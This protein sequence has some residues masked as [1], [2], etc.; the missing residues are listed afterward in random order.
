MVYW[1]SDV[2]QV[3]S[4]SIV[5]VKNE[6]ES[7]SI[8][9]CDVTELKEQDLIRGT[10][11][12]K[13][14]ESWWISSIF[15]YCLIFMF[16]YRWLVCWM[17]SPARSLEEFNDVWVYLCVCLPQLE[18]EDYQPI[19][20]PEP[21]YSIRFRFLIPVTQLFWGMGWIQ[22]SVFGVIYIFVFSSSQARCER[23]L[24]FGER[25]VEFW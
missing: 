11:P 3:R 5:W 8:W 4:K 14:T 13:I 24:L 15:I 16:Y 17:F 2:W 20:T 19:F 22:K 9:G 7:L 21:L 1:K 18:F 10:F 6:L 12:I 23:S 25:V